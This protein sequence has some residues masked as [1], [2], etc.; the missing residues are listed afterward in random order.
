MDKISL[1]LSGLARR[2]RFIQNEVRPR[3][4][5]GVAM[6]RALAVYCTFLW[7]L[8][9]TEASAENASNLMHLFGGILQSAIV[10][11]TIA[12][13]RKIPVDELSCIDD[14]LQK[15]GVSVQSLM[16]QGIA[17]F[18]SRLSD[19]RSSCRAKNV[20]SVPQSAAIIV[21]NSPTSAYTVEGLA[22]GA[23]VS[24][25]SN[26]YHEYDCRPSEQFGRFTWCHREKSESGPRGAIRSS[27]TILHSEDG[28]V[29]YVNRELD[30]ALFGGPH[31]VDIEIERLSGRF[32][33]APHIMRIPAGTNHRLGNG[34]IAV[35]GKAILE[36]L[37]A[38]SRV[39]L[40]AG[41]SPRRGILVDYLGNFQRS[42][43]DDL[44][45]FRV[46]GGAGFVWSA[47]FDGGGLGRLRFFA[48]DSSTLTANEPPVVVPRP[49]SPD[50]WKDCQSADAETRLKGC[51]IVVDAKGDGSRTRLADALDGR[52]SAYNEKQDYE[53]AI[54]DCK[55]AIEVNPRYSY[56][57]GNLGISYLKLR[58][59]PNAISALDRSIDLKTDFL[60]S[61]LNR[62]QAFETSGKTRP[63][64]MDYQ[65]AL[66]IDPSNH[67][68]TEGVIR[69]SR[70]LSATSSGLTPFSCTTELPA[71]DP[72]L[73]ALPSSADA[74]GSPSISLLQHAISQLE[75]YIR[76]LNDQVSRSMDRSASLTQEAETIGAQLTARIA[77]PRSTLADL[78]KLVTSSLEIRSNID[79]LSEQITDLNSKMDRYRKDT[80]TRSATRKVLHQL[81]SDLEALSAQR[82]SAETD[83]QKKKTAI[84]SARDAAGREI[85]EYA[86]L[87][88]KK[89]GLEIDADRFRQCAEERKRRNCG[90]VA[91]HP[92]KTKRRHSTRQALKDRH[93]L[94]RG[95]EGA[96]GLRRDYPALPAMRF[97]TVFF[98]R[99]MD[100]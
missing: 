70:N 3:K 53:H 80:S 94:H 7:L 49:P 97:E 62:A 26:V 59:Y 21:Q 15:R 78:Q 5:Y 86:G 83:L 96:V 1:V 4:T 54:L 51:T 77:L 17:P 82:A 35:W 81:Q 43:Q 50:P 67:T 61:H 29:A 91:T 60:W 75:D 52:C 44:P 22:L 18:D 90:I 32:G 8:I 10:Q 24:F 39:Q 12:E 93:V 48:I 84:D 87:Y 85:S 47:S 13:W 14:A 2:S 25:N 28:T 76:A 30:S 58:D 45:V 46:I 20:P 64:L 57:Y 71:T 66:V 69:L 36:P 92:V 16:Q 95:Y 56:A 41:K 27:Y 63:A 34:V 33:N 99:A 31:E 37:D 98:K 79:H 6:L 65:Y 23:K 9:A 73:A 72:R 74:P 100:R 89:S 42:V 40:A 88:V 55:A 38:S 19:V 11:A 68:A